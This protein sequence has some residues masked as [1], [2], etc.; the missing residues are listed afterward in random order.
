LRIIFFD[1][2]IRGM[3]ATDTIRGRPIGTG[4]KQ[5]DAVRR[6]REVLGLTQEQL[7]RELNCS[8]SAVRTMERNNR[9]PGYG[10]LLNAF[11]RVAERAQ[12]NIEDEEDL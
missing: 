10:K 4:A 11:K 9:L 8:L 6:V 7:A 5:S 12:I 3:K 1:V 2:K